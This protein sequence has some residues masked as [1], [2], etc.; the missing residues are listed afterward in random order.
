MEAAM[1][2]FICCFWM[3][4]ISISLITLFAIQSYVGDLYEYPTKLS[5][6]RVIEFFIGITILLFC[7]VSWTVC[8]LLTLGML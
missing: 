1:L 8:I 5:I 3:A 7:S 4:N 6:E 2:I